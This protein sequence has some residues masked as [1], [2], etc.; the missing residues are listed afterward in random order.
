MFLNLHGD[1]Y[2]YQ[3]QIEFSQKTSV[4]TVVLSSEDT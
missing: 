1:A 4:L 3:K 2:L